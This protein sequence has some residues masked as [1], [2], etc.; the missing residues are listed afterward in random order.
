[1]EAHTNARDLVNFFEDLLQ[2]QTDGKGM[3]EDMRT[4]SLHLCLSSRH[5]PYISVQQNI[6]LLEMHMEHENSADIRQYI[7]MK[8]PLDKDVK[9]NSE[10]RALQDNYFMAKDHIGEVGEEVARRAKS[11]F[12]W[13]VLAI[14][15]LKLAQDRGK[16]MREIRGILDRIPDA[17]NDFFDQILETLTQGDRSD[18]FQLLQFVIFVRRGV[19]AI[20]AQHALAFRAE[21]P[22]VS[23]EQWRKSDE[24]LGP[25]KFK[26]RV[27][28][29]SRGLVEVVPTDQEQTQSAL[30]FIHE[31]VRVF[32]LDQGCKRLL[33]LHS[34][35]SPITNPISMIHH[36]FVKTC[37]NYLAAEDVR[38]MVALRTRER[39]AMGDYESLV[40]DLLE[41]F[42]FLAYATCEIQGHVAEAD[43]QPNGSSRLW[44]LQKFAEDEQGVF[45]TWQN[46]Q[47]LPPT[48]SMSHLDA[49][50]KWKD[51]GHKISGLEY[52]AMH[53]IPTPISTILDFKKFG[54]AEMI[55]A[56]SQ[57][58]RTGNAT[59]AKSLVESMP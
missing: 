57:I 14:N 45:T 24:F 36:H 11:V 3:L 35:P 16:S 20:T 23:V 17:L 2:T 43:A 41:M 50:T 4:R 32:F 21:P 25:E 26:R 18:T 52:V 54:D 44:M 22:P 5:Y 30:Q 9:P 8:L 38:A 27:E 51:Y 34:S 6:D 13:V 7:R 53:E 19:D 55:S 56:L 28:D 58:A 46:L 10:E 59:A 12:L 42:P 47:K 15:D 1:M 40:K 31:T 39:P 29:T 33:T 48:R 37:F 49:F